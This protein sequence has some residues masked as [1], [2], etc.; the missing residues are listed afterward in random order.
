MRDSFYRLPALAL[1]TSVM[2][3]GW[4]VAGA[5]AEDGATF[6]V[7]LENDAFSPTEIKVPA[8]AAF[9]LKVVNN[10]KSGVEIEAKDLKIEK[11]AAAGTE[12]IARVK[13]LSQA[14]TY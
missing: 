3:S 11:V 1:A 5:H 6:T 14:N 12:I 7:I 2:A 10:E 8:G 9:M 13:P 4:L